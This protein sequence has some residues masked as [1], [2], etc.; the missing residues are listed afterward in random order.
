[1]EKPSDPIP[2]APA[3]PAATSPDHE[4]SSGPTA[5][6]VPARPGTEMLGKVYTFPPRVAPPVP[7]NVRKAQVRAALFRK[8]EPVR[9]GRFILLEPI[10]AGAMGE[11]YAAYDD[12]LDRKVALKLVRG[13]SGLTAKADERLLREA[14]TLAQVS[15]PNVVQ[16]YE[17]GTYNG[18]L[19]LAMELIRGKTLTSWL[20]DAAQVPRAVRQREIL[21][22][23]I[24]AGRGLEAAHAAGVAHRDFKPDNVL[25]GDDGRVR[26]VDFGLAR[27]LVNEPDD[28]PA[29]SSAERDEELERAQR[30]MEDML[31]AETVTSRDDDEDDDG[32]LASPGVAADLAGGQTVTLGSAVV[33][34]DAAEATID[35]APA[36]VRRPR[37]GGLT[38]GPASGP[39]SGPPSR[40][41]ERRLT[42]TGTVMGTPSYM[43]PETLRGAAPDRR[44]DQFSFCVALYHALYDTFP[45]SGR[46]LRELRDAME[47]GKL[48]LVPSVP[49]PAV[50]RKALVRGLSVDPAQRF[51]S[52]GELLAALSP[53]PRRLR[54]WVAAGVG[55]IGV[56]LG[57][58][59]YLRAPAVDP[60]AAAG[61]AIDA[62]WSFDRQAALQAAFGRS[63]LPFAGPAW[64]GVKLRLDGYAHGWRAAATAACQA[65]HVVHTQSAQQL[66]KRML[67]LDRG[68]RQ[69]AALVTELGTGAPDAVAHAIEATEALPEL[70]ACSRAENLLFGLAPPPVPVAPQVATARDRL[71]QARTSEL[72]GRSEEALALAREVSATTRV[73]GY[74]PV[75]AEALAQIA[76]ALDARG[77]AAARAEAEPLYFEALDI[78]EAERHDQLAVEIW[79]KLVLLAVR[80]DSGSKQA[81][82]WWQRNAAAVHRIGDDAYEL[83]KLHHM[84][85]ELYY[86]ETK[87]ALAASEE[88]VAIA[89]IAAAPAHQLELSRY[90]DALGKSL[91]H[92]GDVDAALQLHE[93]AL[94][95]ATEAL[96]AGHR[97]V[98]KLETNYGEALRVHGQLDRARSVL[99]G[100]LASMSARD[101]DTHPDA[102][103]IHNVLSDLDNAEGDL[104]AAAEHGRVMLEIYQRT[105]PPGHVLLADAYMTLANVEQRR[106]RFERAL[107]IY[108]DA[109]VLRRRYFANDHFK[110][111][112]NEGGIAET[113]LELGRH[114]E[115]MTHLVEAERTFQ[116]GS[117]RD[118]GIEAWIL[119]VRGEILAGQY[120]PGA[121][122]PVLEQ[123]LARFGDNPADAT[124]HALA[125]W[126]L[127]R[128]LDEL[129]R[130]GDRV[131]VLAQRAHAIFAAQGEVETHNRDAVAHFLDRLPAGPRLR[132]PTQP[133]TSQETG[134]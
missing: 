90:D 62:P 50:V 78:A 70:A 115:A 22:Q 123:A 101:R 76:R 77:T 46:S 1:M 100:A 79:N 58:A 68:R 73:L 61:A 86:V 63:E 25:V 99:E 14:Q 35:H 118:P 121:A 126:T 56:V 122:I 104:D 30:Q 57:T 13:G 97:N 109:L 106:R 110:T 59:A 45:F 132:S 113:L 37:G 51:A 47:S 40:K 5:R 71:A 92:L 117:G 93:R 88:R 43:A 20:E 3:G 72:L 89:A 116:R 65:T 81:L 10:G 49:V 75:H 53:R 127:A 84:R 95:L 98:I 103:K 66:D 87:Y 21:R 85:G 91:E 64:R 111:G 44:S 42:E 67:C 80:L 2:A 94:A 23:F 6:S 27:A 26:V 96:G 69:L 128:A 48:E 36:S 7:S 133:T 8:L 28:A 120:Q 74:P 134:P 16:I 102:A 17:A 52:M 15:H 108:E 19:F 131:R 119:T 11:I 124:N 33:P 32:P 18:R 105:L 24:A 41:A 107:A 4:A 55:L 60:C 82:A 29:G 114:D 130:D 83:A 9:I 112:V 125:M 39:A 129:G 54:R 34:G 12:Q 38:S 31:A